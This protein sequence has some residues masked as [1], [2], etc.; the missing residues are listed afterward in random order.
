MCVRALAKTEGGGEAPPLEK[1]AYEQLQFDLPDIPVLQLLALKAKVDSALAPKTHTERLHLDQ[2][3]LA[4]RR[5][6]GVPADATLRE[7]APH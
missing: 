1:A 5:N 7:G 3:R 2:R 4:S 6:E